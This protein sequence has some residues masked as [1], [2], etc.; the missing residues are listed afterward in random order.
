MGYICRDIDSRNGMYFIAPLAT[1][2]KITHSTSPQKCISML[3]AYVRKPACWS[4]HESVATQ[5]QGEA[6]P[7]LA[8][9]V[10]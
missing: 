10:S 3:H 1:K 7:V 6:E 4:M 2:V 9:P 8:R 5:Q